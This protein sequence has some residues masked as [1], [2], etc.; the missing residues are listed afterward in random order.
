MENSAFA[1]KG[2]T[3][4]ERAIL[5]AMELIR[6]YIMSDGGD[7]EVVSANE[8][9]GVVEIRMVGACAGCPASS[10]TLKAGIEKHLKAEVPQVKEVRAVF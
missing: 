2:L 9:D 1:E 5:E 7:V 10:L 3:D 6:P 8:S 4:F